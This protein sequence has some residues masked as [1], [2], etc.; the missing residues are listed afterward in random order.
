MSLS[1]SFSTSL[2]A[3]NRVERR[4]YNSRRVGFCA[5]PSPSAAKASAMKVYSFVP[6]ST[7]NEMAPLGQIARQ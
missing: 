7:A 6:S 1:F 3:K 4:E 5:D 2:S